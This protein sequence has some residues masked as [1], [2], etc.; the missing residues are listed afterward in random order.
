MTR[1]TTVS[2]RPHESVLP[3]P[4]SGRT[5][6][7]NHG[8]LIGMDADEALLER[9]KV[10]LPKLF[11]WSAAIGVGGAVLLF[12]LPLVRFGFERINLW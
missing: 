2:S 6:Y 3:L 11:W 8:D 12:G 9:A 4:K 7:D 10:I 1:Y 5:R